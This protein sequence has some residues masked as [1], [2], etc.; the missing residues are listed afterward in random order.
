MSEPATGIAPLPAGTPLRRVPPGL[1][2]ELVNEDLDYCVCRLERIEGE[3][4]AKIS[5]YESRIVGLLEEKRKIETLELELRELKSR[6]SGTRSL[7]Y[8]ACA[9]AALALAR[10]IF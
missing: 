10:A 2:Q 7:V 4:G 3:V 5:A 1:A 9:A 8:A 6:L